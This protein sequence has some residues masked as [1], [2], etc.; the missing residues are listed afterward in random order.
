VEQLR[1]RAEL[2]LSARAYMHHYETF[3]VSAE[4]MGLAVEGLRGVVADYQDLERTLR[5]S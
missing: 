3:G 2:M 4:E 5:S 1:L